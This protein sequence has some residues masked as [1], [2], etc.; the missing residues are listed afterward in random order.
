VLG[1]VSVIGKDLRHA[2]AVAA[3]VLEEPPRVDPIPSE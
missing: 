1:E 3:S 2:R